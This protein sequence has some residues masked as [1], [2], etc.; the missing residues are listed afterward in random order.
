[1]SPIFYSINMP[2]CRQVLT[3]IHKYLEYIKSIEHL[4][5]QT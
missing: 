5:K 1:M 3:H 2:H 4:Q